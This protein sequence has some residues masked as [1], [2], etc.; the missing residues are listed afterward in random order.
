[1]V[2]EVYNFEYS[3]E[4]KFEN[5][6]EKDFCK[7]LNNAFYRKTMENVRNCLILEFIEKMKIKKY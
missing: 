6:C 3:K 2:G 7:L 5:G 1:M 4:K